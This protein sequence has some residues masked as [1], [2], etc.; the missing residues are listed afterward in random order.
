MI[1]GSFRK[2]FLPQKDEIFCMSIHKRGW[3]VKV[4]LNKTETIFNILLKL[5]M[6]P[7]VNLPN[8]NPNPYQMPLILLSSLCKLEGLGFHALLKPIHSYAVN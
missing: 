4:L 8:S 6:Y 1:D 5:A 3:A 2:A 7:G